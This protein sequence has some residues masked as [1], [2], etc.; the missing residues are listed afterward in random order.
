MKLKF[1]SPP[2]IGLRE[3]VRTPVHWVP[4]AFG[5]GL[6]PLVPG[7]WTSALTVLAYWWIGPLP[8][9]LLAALVLA[10]LAAGIWLCG[11]SA[12]RL[13]A[14]DPSVIVWDEVVGMLATLL[15]VPDQ[16]GWIW[17]LGAFFAFRIMDI[18]KPW[19]I[20]EVDHRLRG[21]AGIMLDD[22]LAAAYAAAVLGAL[23]L[24][25]PVH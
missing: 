23:G 25:V 15:A 21:G 5:A 10:C 16:G 9:P 14:E 18:W 4:T 1:P 19:P 24:L 11:A 3:V 12:R 6:L 13:E 2:T 17:V 22:V 20:R 7:T 8:K